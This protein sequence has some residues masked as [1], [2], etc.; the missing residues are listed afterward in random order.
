MFFIALCLVNVYLPEVYEWED[1]L[2]KAWVYWERKRRLTERSYWR[3]DYA[4]ESWNAVLGY[5]GDWDLHDV[6]GFAI[7][8]AREVQSVIG[9]LDV[10]SAVFADIKN[11]VVPQV[12]LTAARDVHGVQDVLDVHPREAR[13]DHPRDVPDVRG[14]RGVHVQPK[15]MPR[16][17]GVH[18][19]PKS[20]PRGSVA[21]EPRPKWKSKTMPSPK[22]SAKP[23]SSGAGDSQGSSGQDL[24]PSKKPRKSTV[25]SESA[26]VEDEAN[27]APDESGPPIKLGDWFCSACN[28]HNHAWRGFCNG[29]RSGRPCGKPRDRG[30]SLDQYWY[31]ICGNLN[32]SFR[33]KCNRWKCSLLREQGEQDPPK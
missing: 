26:E 16:G 30:F 31:C 11:L 21:L 33:T 4:Q 17:S 13:D 14:V 20:M 5:F 24:P 19:K 23:S 3:H 2:R 18:V 7:V 15:S 22:P 10:A 32:K 6:G 8:L 1:L 27:E 28:N 29:R 12:Q 9:N 25:S